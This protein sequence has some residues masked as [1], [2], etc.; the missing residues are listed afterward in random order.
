MDHPHFT[1]DS[2]H[3]DPSAEDDWYFDNGSVHA[4]VTIEG[5]TLRLH[6]V[7]VNDEVLAGAR[8]GLGRKAMTE[9]RELFP[10]IICDGAIHPFRDYSNDDKPLL[11][12][13]AMLA[14][15]L[16]D[17][18][19]LA[20]CATEIRREHLNSEIETSF[21]TISLPY[22]PASAHTPR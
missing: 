7:G 18:M 4:I 8:S 21:G 14:E 10:C 12:W 13:Q 3:L 22:R 11:F 19:V 15:G 20:N 17:I 16:I 5:S 2:D 6:D 9:L 1:Q